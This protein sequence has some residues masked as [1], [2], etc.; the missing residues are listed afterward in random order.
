MKLGITIT[1]YSWPGGPRALAGHLVD[2]AQRVDD[3]GIDTVWVADHLLQMDPSASVDEPMLEAYSTL[4]FIAASAR[5]VELGT[6][7]TWAPIR[8]P[9][10]LVKTPRPARRSDRGREFR[11]VLPRWALPLTLTIAGAQVSHPR[12]VLGR[13]DSEEPLAAV[14]VEELGG[15]DEPVEPDQRGHATTVAFHQGPPVDAVVNSRINSEA[16]ERPRTPIA[17]RSAD[18]PPRFIAE[19]AANLMRH[20]RRRSVEPRG[21]EGRHHR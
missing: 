1:N 9:A 18:T 17:Q 19:R 13:L 4:A 20:C 3:A 11:G 7:V 6:M 14:V 5:R 12:A 10:L 15:H 21:A 16:P 8:P 2:V